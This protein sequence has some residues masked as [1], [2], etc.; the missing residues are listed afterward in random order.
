MYYFL[1]C[2]LHSPLAG[3]NYFDIVFYFEVQS[4]ISLILLAI[5]TYIQAHYEPVNDSRYQPS[6]RPLLDASTVA[7]TITIGS[8]D[9]LLDYIQ[10]GIHCG[11]FFLDIFPNK[12]SL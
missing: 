8:L 3:S 12:E 5:L 11:G 9:S 7:S 4:F 2:S 1:S 10:R 6:Q